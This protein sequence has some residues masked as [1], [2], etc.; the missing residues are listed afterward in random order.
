MKTQAMV[1]KQLIHKYYETQNLK[2]IN[3]LI[4]KE[5]INYPTIGK[6]I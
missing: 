6:D 2:S 3:K 4:Q 5:R 1:K